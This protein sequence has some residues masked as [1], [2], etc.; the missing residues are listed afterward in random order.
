ML[1]IELI[2][3]DPLGQF[4][5]GPGEIPEQLLI[6]L[7]LLHRIQIFPDEVLDERVQARV[8]G[9]AHDGRY[10]GEPSL[11]RHANDAHRL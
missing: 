8:R 7:S 4:I 5:L 2:L 3:S 1:A 10:C 11:G 9:L 6:R